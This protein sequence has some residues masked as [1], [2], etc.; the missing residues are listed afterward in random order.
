[1]GAREAGFRLR[2]NPGGLE[3]EDGAS[4]RKMAA[5]EERS[6]FRFEDDRPG[7]Q[8]GASGRKMTLRIER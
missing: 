1:M 3:D 6:G 8:D 4:G 2:E 5:P 7:S